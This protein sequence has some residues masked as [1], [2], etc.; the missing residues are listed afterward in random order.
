MRSWLIT[1]NVTL[2]RPIVY[3]VIVATCS[4]LPPVVEVF[5]RFLTQFLISLHEILQALF[6]TIPSLT[7]KIS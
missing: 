3:N 1:F 5:R 4:Q 6:P 2:G 7:Q